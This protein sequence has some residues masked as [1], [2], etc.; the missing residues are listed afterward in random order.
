M[1][2][3]KYVKTEAVLAVLNRCCCTAFFI[4]LIKIL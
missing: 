1:H 3:L 4:T 2:T